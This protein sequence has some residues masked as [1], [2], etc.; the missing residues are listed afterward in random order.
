VLRAVEAHLDERS[1]MTIVVVAHGGGVEAMLKGAIDAKGVRYAI[2]VEQLSR[3]G[4]DFAVCGATLKSRGIGHD[5]V[6]AEG[7]IV[8]RGSGEIAR[9]IGLGYQPLN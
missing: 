5:R 7:R 9:L 8:P 6:I 3:R 1:R 4:V 2:A